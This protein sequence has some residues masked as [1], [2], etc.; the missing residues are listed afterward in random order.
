MIIKKNYGLCQ[1]HYLSVPALNWDAMLNIP[2]FELELISDADMYLS[3][4]KG[5]GDRFSYISKRYRKANNKY[6]KSYNPK[7][8][9]KHII[10]LDPNN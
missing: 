9:S 10:Y 5:M 4:E 2:K 7:Q 3:F 8:E 1:S 6:L